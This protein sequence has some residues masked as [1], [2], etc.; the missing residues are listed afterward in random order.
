MNNQ[1]NDIF[2]RVRQEL[3]DKHFTIAGENL[4]KPWGAYFLIAEKQTPNFLREYFPQI[5]QAEFQPGLK[6]SPKILLV[7]PHMR[8]SWQ[9]H[10]RRQELWRVLEGPVGVAL[11]KTDE[12][13]PARIYQVNEVIRIALGE[14]HRLVGLEQWGVVAE[15]WTHTDPNNP[16]TEEDIVRVQDDFSR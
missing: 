13:V 8:L 12:E 14:R 1:T 2:E 15:I 7:A 10:H 16:S 9:Y 4:D 6:L 5:S 3:Q 11:N